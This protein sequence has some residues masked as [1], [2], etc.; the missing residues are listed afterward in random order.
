MSCFLIEKT[1]PGV[2]DFYLLLLFKIFTADF[3]GRNIVHKEGYMEKEW[4]QKKHRKI[5]RKCQR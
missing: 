1:F 2:F 5:L 4:I 3:N